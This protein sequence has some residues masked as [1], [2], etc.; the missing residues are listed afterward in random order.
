[1]K[2]IIPARTWWANAK[3]IFRELLDGLLPFA[4]HAANQVFR[5][6]ENDHLSCNRGRPGPVN[7]KTF[8]TK[9]QRCRLVNRMKI[10]I[11][12]LK[13]NCAFC[14]GQSLLTVR[15]RNEKVGTYETVRCVEKLCESL[16]K[17]FHVF[18]G[19]TYY[20]SSW[21]VKKGAAQVSN[22]E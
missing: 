7:F 20:S 18:W 2:I 17:P 3:W 15:V 4:R 1:M 8:K 6:W 10:E 21:N 14:L 11:F 13:W 22:E 12:R 5:H 9:I 19:C 16:W